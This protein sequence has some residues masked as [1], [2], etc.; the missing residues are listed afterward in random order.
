MVAGACAERVEAALES[1]AGAV[2]G[3]HFGVVE[4]A[5]ED[6]CGEGFVAEGVGPFTDGLVAGARGWRRRGRAAC[7]RGRALP[8][9]G[10]RRCGCCR[11]PGPRIRQP[12]LRAMKR[13]ER[14]SARRWG[15]SSGWKLWSKVV[16]RFVV[17]QAGHLQPGLVAAA[18]ELS[19]L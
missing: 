10:P 4:E 6:R 8:S 2:D 9:P 3:E 1:E 13:S 14:S 19:D 17:R 16:E 7:S 15:S 5:A 12:I 11:R 18:L